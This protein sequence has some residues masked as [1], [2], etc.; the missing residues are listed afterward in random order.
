M[1][2]RVFSVPHFGFH[3]ATATPS[4]CLQVQAQIEQEQQDAAMLR[5][6][7]EMQRQIEARDVW[8]RFFSNEIHR[9]GIEILGKMMENMGKMMEK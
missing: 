9:N 7:R 2:A 8:H 5:Q 1:C 3:Q 6:R 4:F